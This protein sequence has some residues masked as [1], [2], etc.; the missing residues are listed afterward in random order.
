MLI[1][2]GFDGTSDATTSTMVFS[3][4]PDLPV[5]FLSW[6]VNVGCWSIIVVLAVGWIKK[7]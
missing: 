3:E 2:G 1:T 5:F 6:A 4:E 7:S